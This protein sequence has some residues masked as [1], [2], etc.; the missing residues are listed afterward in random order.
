MRTYRTKAGPFKEGNFY[1]DE[2]IDSLCLDEL[3]NARLLPSSPSAVRID[4]FVEKR[5]G[6]TPQYENLPDGVLGMTIFGSSGV[7]AVIVA[8]SLDEDKS[9]VAERR[10]R[11]TIAHEA[12]HGLLHTH[13]FALAHAERPLFGDFSDP[14]KPKVL[15]RDVAGTQGGPRAGYDGKWWE[16]QANAVMGSLLLPRPLVELALAPFFVSRGSLG[17]KLLD[18]DRREEA[19][20]HLSE[21]FDANPIV[22]RLRINRLFPPTN[23]MQ[24]SL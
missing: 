13:L 19:A 16:F 21:V 9:T 15:C 6:V 12:G 17:A 1:S 11:S 3:Q 20:R 8:Q 23:E 22:A 7:E 18:G 2:E 5:F 4:R 10:I 14:H 24:L